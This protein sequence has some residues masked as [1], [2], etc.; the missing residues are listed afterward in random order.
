MSPTALVRMVN[1]DYYWP[2]KKVESALGKKLR[3]FSKSQIAVVN[4]N[5]KT[6]R[7]REPEI[8]FFLRLLSFVRRFPIVK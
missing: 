8:C 1:K 3:S 7:R 5:W 2:S 6:G 4:F